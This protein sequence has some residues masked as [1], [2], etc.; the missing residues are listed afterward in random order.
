MTPHGY[1]SDEHVS[2]QYRGSISHAPPSGHG[3]LAHRRFRA[4]AFGDVRASISG[5]ST[6]TMGP[7]SKEQFSYTVVVPHQLQLPTATSSIAFTSPTNKH[8]DCS[9]VHEAPSPTAHDSISSGSLNDNE[10]RL[11]AHHGH[12]CAKATA[13]THTG[14]PDHVREPDEQ[15]QAHASFTRV[16]TPRHYASNNEH[17]G[18]PTRGDP[19]QDARQL[20]VQLT[21]LR[22]R[23]QQAHATHDYSRTDHNH[24]ASQPPQAPTTRRPAA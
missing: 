17:N 3:Y 14:S 10:G 5:G 6:Q 20:R 24:A 12:S 16:R 9:S 7:R 18:T 15:Q 1:G 23:K 22:P 8:K 21:P 19:R 11:R 4:C 2:A 13:T